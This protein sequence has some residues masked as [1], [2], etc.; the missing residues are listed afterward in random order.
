MPRVLALGLDPAC[1]DP[2]EFSGFSA[3]QVRAFIES[4]LDRVRA[5]GYDVLSCYVDLG[6]TAEA[7][8]V[9]ALSSQA[10]DCVMIGAG[11]RAAAQLVL[12]EKLINLLH[13]QAPGARIC[14]NSSPGDTLEAVRRWV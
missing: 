13:A 4:Q 3:E 5:A 7:V 14:F 1:V 8:T 9:R 11:L 12:F 2:Q 6:E 10:F